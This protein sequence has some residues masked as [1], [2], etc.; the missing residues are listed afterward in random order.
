M[1]AI[2]TLVN[3][4]TMCSNANNSANL[5]LL[6]AAGLNEEQVRE[7][8]KDWR[9]VEVLATRENR[10]QALAQEYVEEQ[11][12][13]LIVVSALGL[14]VTNNNYMELAKWMAMLPQNSERITNV[15]NNIEEY[16]GKTPECCLTMMVDCCR[17]QQGLK[18]S[19]DEIRRNK[20]HWYQVANIAAL[21]GCADVL[22]H[23]TM[24]AVTGDRVV[25][26]VLDPFN[27]KHSEALKKELKG[28]LLAL[29]FGRLSPNSQTIVETW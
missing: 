13:S 3:H 9:Y 16:C 25:E 22:R 4:F 28:F 14:V 1:E 18:V 20:L 5:A 11:I 23:L 7:L 21:E 29:P 2:I 27:S 6:I 17:I 26:L 15:Y 24:K 8:F 12:N 10:W 19:R